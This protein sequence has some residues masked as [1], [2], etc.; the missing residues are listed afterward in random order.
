[1]NWKIENCRACGSS[2]LELVLNLGTTPLADALLRAD[3]LDQPEVTAPLEVVFCTRCA[4]LQ[5]NQNV[6]TDILF[7]RD[8]PYYSSV[9]KARLAHFEESARRLIASRNLSP[10]D[11]VVEA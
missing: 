6:L 8:Y 10:R 9:S 11:L 2:E 7:C 3:Q 4:L 5:I 1:M